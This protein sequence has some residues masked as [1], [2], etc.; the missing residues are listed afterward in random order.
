LVRRGFSAIPNFVTSLR[1]SWLTGPILAGQNEANI[2]V[3]FS[4]GRA[5][6]ADG[7]QTQ[8]S[9][10]GSRAINPQP[11]VKITDDAHGGGLV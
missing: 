8:R 5:R 11:A 3:D 1:T 2:G 7:L 6:R 4:P 10:G 9:I